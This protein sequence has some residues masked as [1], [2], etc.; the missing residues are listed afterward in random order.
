MKPEVQQGLATLMRGR[1]VI[2]IA[3]SASAVCHTDHVIILG[4][5]GSRPS[6]HRWSLKK[7]SPFCRKLMPEG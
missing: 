5:E 7:T 3:H 1:T 2:E 6:G 4:K